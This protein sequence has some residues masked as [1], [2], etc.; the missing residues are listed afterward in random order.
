MF[1]VS[2][3]QQTIFAISSMQEASRNLP[4]HAIIF[5]KEKANESNI[6][7]EKLIESQT[8]YLISDG[9]YL[10]IFQKTSF[11]GVRFCFESSNTLSPADLPISIWSVVDDVAFSTNCDVVQVVLDKKKDDYVHFIQ[12]TRSFFL[13]GIEF[14]T[15]QN[16]VGTQDDNRDENILVTQSIPLD[17]MMESELTSTWSHPGLIPDSI[18][19]IAEIWRCYEQRRLRLENNDENLIAYAYKIHNKTVAAILL[20]RYKMAFGLS[21]FLA[22][23][24]VWTHPSFRGR[25]IMPA[26]EQQINFDYSKSGSSVLIAVATSNYSSI[27]SIRKAKLTP[28]AFFMLKDIRQY[29]VERCFL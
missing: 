15:N 29:E 18:T 21:P 3:N 4:E 22:A 9:S 26:I 20:E 1:F 8:K 25:G 23:Q 14:E 5:L 16:I 24:F 19:T 7:V 27:A 12:A 28:S 11:F 6:E 2:H 10:A 13:A 17:L